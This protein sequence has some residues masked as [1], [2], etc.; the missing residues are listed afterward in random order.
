MTKIGEVMW[1]EK[2]RPQ[3]LDDIVGNED[4]VERLKNYVDDPGMPHLILAGPPGV[5]KTA[6][7]TALAREKYGDNWKNHF[8][9]LNASD[10]RGIDTIRDKVKGIA[11]QGTTGGADH[12]IIFLDEADQLSRD[13]QPALRRIFEDF[14]DVTRF[15]LSVNYP[16][17]VISP[18]QSRCSM[19]RFS[20]LT[21]EQVTATLIEIAE[22]EGVDYEPDAIEALAR[23][24][25]GDMRS[26]INAL[27]SAAI[28]GEVTEDVVS[29]IVGIVDDDLVG[30]ILQKAMEGDVDTAMYL[31][32]DK[33]LKEGANVEL[34][35]ESF[36]RVIKGRDDIP[37]PAKMKLLEKLA[38]VEWRVRRAS[39]PSVQFHSFLADVRVARHLTLGDSYPTEENYE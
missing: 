7:I 1:T 31:L 3:T 8:T 5:G 15:A 25:R 18:I 23:D 32:D 28:E 14:H 36:L 37:A 34:L 39:N 38:D 16:S 4:A 24:A 11:R 19:F 2:F 30:T 13:A 22:A 33:L 6:S 10:E 35:A 9:E 21:D 27:Q 17:Q 26:A 12:K 20:R 29:S